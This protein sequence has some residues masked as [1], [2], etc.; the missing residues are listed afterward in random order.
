VWQQLHHFLDQL[1]REGKL[2]RGGIPLAACV[3]GSH[4]T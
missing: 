2:D 4:H 1:G 3:S